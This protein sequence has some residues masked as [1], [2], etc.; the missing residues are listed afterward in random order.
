[1][2]KAGMDIQGRDVN[3]GGRSSA[4]S[5]VS[6]GNFNNG[7]GRFNPFAPSSAQ[8]INPITV[9][10]IGAVLVVLALIMK[11]KPKPRKRGRK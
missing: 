9:S 1:M 10:V 4:S 6:F 2:A 5:G 7:G 8:G 11:R 3:A